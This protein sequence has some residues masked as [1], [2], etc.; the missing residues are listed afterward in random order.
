M[1]HM[2]LVAKVVN[3]LV[4]VDRKILHDSQMDY[5]ATDRILHNV[6]ELSLKTQHKRGEIMKSNYFSMGIFSLKNTSIN[7]VKVTR[8]STGICNISSM[9]NANMKDFY[10]LKPTETAF[11]LTDDLMQ[12]I[13]NSR[14][15]TRLIVTVFLHNALFNEEQRDISTSL[16]FGIL[17]TGKDL[18]L[19]IFIVF[20][21]V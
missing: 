4:R 19:S 7:A 8:C 17:I 1:K 20:L 3:G 2:A 16:I 14:N 5:N 15:T 12:Q 21:D 9:R 18:P 10:S 11:L 6:D 13:E